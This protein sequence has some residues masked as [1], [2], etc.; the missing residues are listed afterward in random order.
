MFAN[1]SVRP[2]IFVLCAVCDSYCTI[3]L[4][5]SFLQGLCGYRFSIIWRASFLFKFL[6]EKVF[7]N[8]LCYILWWFAG[9]ICFGLGFIGTN[10]RK[11]SFFTITVH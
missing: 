9:V 8:C 4:L 2:L 3:D 6:M 7:S 11:A 1:S 10:D 5:V